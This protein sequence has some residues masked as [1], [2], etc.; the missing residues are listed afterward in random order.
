MVA[1]VFIYLKRKTSNAAAYRM[2]NKGFG[3]SHKTDEPLMG[4]ADTAAVK[5]EG[6]TF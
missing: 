4:V 1:S 3:F 6:G 5:F 2:K